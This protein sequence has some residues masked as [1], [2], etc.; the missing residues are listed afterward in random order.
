MENNYRD[1]RQ[2]GYSRM[3]MIY[4]VGMACIILC[5]GVFMIWGDT[6]GFEMVKEYDPLMRYL[7]GGLCFLYGSFRFYRAFKH[8]Y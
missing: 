5:I 1:T 4:D 7:F 6:F 2:K 3:R 8:E